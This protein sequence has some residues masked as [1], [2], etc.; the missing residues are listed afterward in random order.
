MNRYPEMIDP[1][2][3]VE[4]RGNEK[5]LH[6]IGK[7]SLATADTRLL[8]SVV[9]TPAFMGPVLTQAWSQF[10]FEGN[11]RCGTCAQSLPDSGIQPE[12]SPIKGLVRQLRDFVK[13]NFPIR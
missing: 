11:V 5:T 9:R 4:V 6:Y 10:L 3:L 13:A 7:E 1:C 8:F 2:L 12:L